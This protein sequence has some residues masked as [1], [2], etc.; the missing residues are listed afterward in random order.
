[1]IKF[2]YIY[3]LQLHFR[4]FWVNQLIDLDLE[5]PTVVSLYCDSTSRKSYVKML[6]EVLSWDYSVN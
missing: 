5:V 4:Q 1:M 2:M 3:S 6:V